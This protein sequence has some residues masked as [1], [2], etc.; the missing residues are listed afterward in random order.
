M[1]LSS[2]V[3]KKEQSTAATVL[4][5]MQKHPQ[6]MVKTTPK[7]IVNQIT[8][9]NPSVKEGDALEAIA[10]MKKDGI[11]NWTSRGPHSTFEINY[12][13]GFVKKY[14]VKEPKKQKEVRIE[15]VK[16]IEVEQPE[17]KAPRKIPVQAEVPKNKD[18][19]INITLEITVKSDGSVEIC[20][21]EK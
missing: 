12:D 17:L 13:H 19:K 21:Q 8:I 16:K 7:T 5:W 1:R 9:L 2:L 14:I 3:S 18:I 15:E 4:L 10:W 11:L 20:K 6:L